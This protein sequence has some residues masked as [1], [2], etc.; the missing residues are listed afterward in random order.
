M[1][2]FKEKTN[3]NNQ[4]CDIGSRTAGFA[5]TEML[6]HAE[7]IMVLQ[8]FGLMKKIPANRTDT[9]KFRRPVPLGPS[10]TPLTEGVTPTSQ[11]MSYEDVG[12]TLNQYGSVIELTDKVDELAE[13]PVLRDAAILAGEQAGQTLENI[14]YGTLCGGTNVYYANGSSRN[15]VNEKLVWA[16]NGKL[17]AV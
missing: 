7:P 15:A 16:C 11:R 3:A 8:K 2:R 4:F 5:V 12:V 1:I 17:P 13:D 10:T 6:N 9:I 14:L